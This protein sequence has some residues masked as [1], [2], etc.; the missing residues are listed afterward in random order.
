LLETLKIFVH[1]YTNFLC[2]FRWSFRKQ[3]FWFVHF[4][5]QMLYVNCVAFITWAFWID[6]KTKISMLTYWIKAFFVWVLDLFW[7]LIFVNKF[8]FVQRYFSTTKEAFC[9]EVT[10]NYH[11]FFYG[12]TKE[13]KKERN[14]NLFGPVE[15]ISLI[16]RSECERILSQKV[17]NFAFIQNWILFQL[18]KNVERLL[19]LYHDLIHLQIYG[20]F[21]YTFVLN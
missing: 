17:L 5:K 21:R 14:V 18:S 13:L 8:I 19:N 12:P 2:F 16:N 10:L 11:I 7:L 4:I 9:I 6:P 1:F 20:L 15:F 3:W